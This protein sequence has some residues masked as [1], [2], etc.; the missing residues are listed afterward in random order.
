MIEEVGIPTSIQTAIMAN[1]EPD[2]KGVVLYP[3]WA[4]KEYVLK[5]HEFKL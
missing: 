1:H 4:D 5:H 2:E 3:G